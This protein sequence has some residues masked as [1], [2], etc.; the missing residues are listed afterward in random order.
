MTPHR[1]GFWFYLTV[2]AIGLITAWWFNGIAVVNGSTGGDYLEAWF[3]SPLDWVLSLDLL[4][5]ALAGSVFIIVEGRR[6]GMR[7]LWAYL[8]A[9]GVT[10]FA[11][12]F[13][14]FLAMRER[15]LARA[16]SGQRVDSD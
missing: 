16:N 5:V 13:P 7:W 12:T 2:S 14:L 8:L 3:S 9:S 11:F 10:A 4:V 15:T 6:L 1:I